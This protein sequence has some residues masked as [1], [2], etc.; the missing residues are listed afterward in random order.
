MSVSRIEEY[1]QKDGA[2]VLK[3]FLVS[4]KA[5][6][7][8]SYFYADAEDLDIVQSQYWGR[9]GTGAIIARTIYASCYLFHREVALKKLGHYPYYPD[10]I[11]HYNGVLFDNC[12][13]NLFITSNRRKGRT[14]GYTFR[15]DSYN[16]NGSWHVYIST[17]QVRKSVKNELEA[18]RL[19]YE[20][21]QAYPT[22]CYNFLEDRSD[23]LDILDMER[24]GQI[25]HEESI[26]RHVI[27]YA[28]NAWYY[29]RY[30]LEQYFKDNHIPVPQYALDDK[31]FMVHPITGV[32]LCPL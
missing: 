15:T 21:E 10:W 25:T 30:N 31:G 13:S 11:D 14:R 24:T 26:Y 4:R 19:R 6:P 17:P 8:G 32:R 7:N 22:Y 1:T 18:C 5:F 27:K 9:K 29:H 28:D 12:D 3:V 20:L 2:G 23:D 16:P